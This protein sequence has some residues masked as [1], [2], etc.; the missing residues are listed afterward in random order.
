MKQSSEKM[1]SAVVDPYRGNAVNQESPPETHFNLK[2]RASLSHQSCR[3][4]ITLHVTV[5]V[6]FL[7][8]IARLQQEQGDLILS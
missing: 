3:Y 2:P 1:I 5:A 4:H 7:F 6:L 8:H